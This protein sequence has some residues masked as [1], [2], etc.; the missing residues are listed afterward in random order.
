MALNLEKQ[1][2]FVRIGLSMDLLP[3]LTDYPSSSMGPTM[4]IR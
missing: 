2:L 1:L 4:I 3:A